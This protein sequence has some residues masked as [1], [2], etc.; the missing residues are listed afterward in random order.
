MIYISYFRKIF[1]TLFL[2][3]GFLVNL[4]AGLGYAGT[5]TEIN[6]LFVEDSSVFK[7]A[8]INARAAFNVDEE[9]PWFINESPEFICTYGYEAVKAYKNCLS[10]G[11]TIHLVLLDINMC[12]LFLDG[13]PSHKKAGI[14]LAMFLRGKPDSI[15]NYDIVRM[16]GK[17]CFLDSRVLNVPTQIFTGPIITA[18]DE[19]YEFLAGINEDQGMFS[20]IGPKIK[21]HKDLKDVISKYAAHFCNEALERRPE[22]ALDVL[23]LSLEN[24]Y[25]DF[26]SPNGARITSER[27]DVSFLGDEFKV[28]ITDCICEAYPDH[29][30]ISESFD[31]IIYLTN[32]YRIKPVF[33]VSVME[34]R[35]SFI[36]DTSDRQIYLSYGLE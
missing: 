21:N 30:L 17:E 10:R 35:V 23:T 9:N 7:K 12:S 6:V 15:Y 28:E 16:C 36:W 26:L 27:D 1:K 32:Y 31:E 11:T 25:R 13:T 34:K 19:T 24:L 18:S 29:C 8:Y 14:E 2:A 22:D 4:C 5:K 3:L 20:E 33:E